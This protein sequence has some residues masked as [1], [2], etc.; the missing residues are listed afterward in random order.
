LITLWQFRPAL[1]LPNASPF[2]M[3]V[4]TWLRLAGLQYRPRTT[5][6][7]TRGPLGK[8]PFVQDGRRRI[9][10]S[11][12]IIEEL[13]KAHG[14]DLDTALDVQARATAHAYAKMLEEHLYWA[15]IYARWLDPAHWPAV[16]RAFFGTLPRGM[17]G[18]VARLA[19]HKIARDAR[20]QGLMLHPPQEV[21]RR[22][23]QD[24]DALAALL[25]G[26]PYMMGRQASTL[27]AIAY[28]FLA[29]CWE[30]QLDT[31][32]KSAVGNHPNLVAYCDRMKQRCF[33]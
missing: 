33:G 25:D 31:P 32:L 11:S 6:L 16:R 22:A 10:D 7:P 29:N 30:A 8:L 14:V 28:A 18:A 3:K 20:G 12:C 21:Y 23:A 24:I 1:G 27:D 17:R 26:Q 2:C 15:L 9:P 4:E 5:L 13:S 19:Q